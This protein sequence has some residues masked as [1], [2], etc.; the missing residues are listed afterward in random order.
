[1]KRV[2]VFVGLIIPVVIAVLLLTC[3]VGWAGDYRIEAFPNED[4]PVGWIYTGT[5][6]FDDAKTDLQT[7]LDLLKRCRNGIWQTHLADAIK[8]YVDVLETLS[9][10]PTDELTTLQKFDF[11]SERMHA[12][13][14]IIAAYE[15]YIDAQL[16]L[17]DEIDQFLEKMEEP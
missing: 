7:A 8:K 4:H 9:K 1:M 3:S 6:N 2:L 17:I 5:F 11:I 14:K 13:H 12:D 16:D 10:T 15:V